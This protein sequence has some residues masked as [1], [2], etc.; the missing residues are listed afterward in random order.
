MKKVEL[1][2]FQIYI[3][4]S[5][6][7]IYKD[8]LAKEVFHENSIVTKEFVQREVATIENKLREALK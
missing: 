6:L 4:I 7:D 8:T 1:T 5:A 3:L 2:E